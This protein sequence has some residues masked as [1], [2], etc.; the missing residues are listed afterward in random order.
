MKF[1][2][3]QNG[4][5]ID[6]KNIHYKESW[7]NGEGRLKFPTSE[8]TAMVKQ[9]KAA[10]GTPVVWY[11]SDEKTRATLELWALENNV[12]GIKFV[13]RQGQA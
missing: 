9:V 12:K 1:D 11:M 8:T 4:T 2:G 3:Y 7:I 5:L 10:N 6:A 13:F